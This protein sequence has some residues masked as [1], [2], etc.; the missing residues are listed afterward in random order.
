M[1]VR[2]Y[3]PFVS[4]WGALIRFDRLIDLKFLETT[5]LVIKIGL[6]LAERRPNVVAT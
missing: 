4:S 2:P 3:A 1:P 6:H 5:S